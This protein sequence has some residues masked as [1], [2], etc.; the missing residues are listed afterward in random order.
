[1][2]NWNGLDFFIFLI[3]ALNTLIGMSRGASKELISMMC[4]SI[5]LIFMIKFTVPLAVFLN[6]SPLINDVVDNTLVKNFMTSIQ[7]GPVTATTLTEIFYSISLLL[8]FMGAYALCEATLAYSGFT[9]SLSFPYATLNRKLGAAIGFTRG[10]VFT[11]ILLVIL[12][13]HLA[14]G[15]N[16]NIIRTEFLSNSFFGNLFHGQVDRLDSLISGQQ[17]GRYREVF[18]GKDLYNVGEVYKQLNNQQKY[19]PNYNP[20]NNN[21]PQNINQQQGL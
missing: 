14:K 10:Y 5:G 8:C 9:E 12:S 17:P 1:M 7:A 20:P 2:N 15:D 3:F 13:V 4:I 18:E 21:S 6:S 16:S 19:I 11:L